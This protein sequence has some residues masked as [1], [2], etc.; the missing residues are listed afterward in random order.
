MNMP[1]W[2]YHAWIVSQTA[3]LLGHQADAEKYARL[4]GSVRQFTSLRQTNPR[5]GNPANQSP[6]QTE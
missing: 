1:A 4:V 5:S 3:A 2:Q 6:W